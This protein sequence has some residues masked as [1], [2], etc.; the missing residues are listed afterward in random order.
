MYLKNYTSEVPVPTTIMRIDHMRG[1]GF[2][3][4]LPEKT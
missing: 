1:S 2:K 4:L 3:A